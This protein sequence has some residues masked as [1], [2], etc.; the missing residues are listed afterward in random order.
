MSYAARVAHN[1]VNDVVRPPNWTRLK[2]RLFR[3]IARTPAFAMWNDPQ[4]GKVCGYVSWKNQTPRGARGS[5]ATLRNSASDLRRDDVL[6]TRWDNMGLTDRQVLLERVFD[7]AGGPI[8][9][10]MLVTFLAE[11]L[12]IGSEISL[13]DLDPDDE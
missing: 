4:L 9:T 13:G 11:L 12:E 3:V 2:N 5:M 8:E 10:T 7:I 1:V 6:A